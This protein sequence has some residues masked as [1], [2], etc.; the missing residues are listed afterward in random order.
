[1]LSK[2]VIF[3]GFFIYSVGLHSAMWDLLNDMQRIA[4]MAKDTD[5]GWI[6]K[7]RTSS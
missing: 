6:S 3:L 7:A 4:H 2:L 1:M 5:H